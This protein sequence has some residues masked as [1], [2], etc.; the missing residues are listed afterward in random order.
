MPTIKNINEL[1][2]LS[3]SLIDDLIQEKLDAK[4]DKGMVAHI[5][6]QI[7]N[8]IHTSTLELKYA[9]HSNKRFIDFFEYKVPIYVK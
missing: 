5:N 7:S 4:E 3:L 8:V 6:K 1:R 2:N 9:K